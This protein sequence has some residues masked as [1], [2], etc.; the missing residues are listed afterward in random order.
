MFLLNCVVF[1]TT[2]VCDLKLAVAA[3]SVMGREELSDTPFAENAG[4]N[5]MTPRGVKVL[6]ELAVFPWMMRREC[7]CNS[8]CNR[9]D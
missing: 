3:A 4:G 8:F 5:S 1:Y 2:V 9:W 7:R 6:Q